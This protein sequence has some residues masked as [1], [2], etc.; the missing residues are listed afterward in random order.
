[1]AFEAT[2]KALYRLKYLRNIQQNATPLSVIT[3]IQ[4]EL[5][6]LKKEQ[7]LILISE[8]NSLISKEI[9]SQPIPFIYER[10][11][12]KFEHYFIDEFQDT[13]EM[14]WKNLTPLMVNALASAKG[15]SCL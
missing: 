9:K 12:E 8:F 13:S 2:R 1:M 3:L 10:I 5:N 11:G 15:L 6:T 7:N 4:K 14:Q